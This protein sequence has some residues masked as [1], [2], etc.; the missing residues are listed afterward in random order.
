LSSPPRAPPSTG[1]C[2]A[3]SR[4]R[5]FLVVNPCRKSCARCSGAMPTRLSLTR[6][7]AFWASSTLITKRLSER[8]LARSGSLRMRFTRT[9]NMRCRSRSRGPMVGALGDR[10][11]ARAVERLM[12]QAQRRLDVGDANRRRSTPP[13]GGWRARHAPRPGACPA[14]PSAQ[15]ARRRAPRVEPGSQIGRDAERARV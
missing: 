9:S 15:R 12:M 7:Q 6:T 14:S 11:D 5:P 10:L 3:R 13:P 4:V 8:V 1:S 2:G